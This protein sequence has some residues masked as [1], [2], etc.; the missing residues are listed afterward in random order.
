MEGSGC[1][2]QPLEEL[3]ARVSG[4][5]KKSSLAL[6]ASVMAL[7]SLGASAQQD[8]MVP[9]HIRAVKVD[10]TAWQ[11][12]QAGGQRER[13]SEGDF[14]RQGNVVETASDGS[15]ILLFDNGSTMNLR[16]GSKFSI[17]EFL[18]EPFD[19]QTIDYRKIE[20]E[21]SKSVTKVAIKE[22]AVFFDIPKLKISKGSSYNISNPVGTAGI[23]GTAGFV[24]QDSMGCTSGSFQA[25]TQTGQAMTLTAGQTTGFAPGGNFGPPPGNA[26]QNM[27]GAQQNSQT[28]RQDV[29]AEPF[30][31]APSQS[32]LSGN[33]TELTAEQ[34]ESIEQAAKQGEEALVEAVKQV[35][36]ENPESAAA[37]AALAASLNPDAAP[38]IAAAAA[39]AVPQSQSSALAP[40][41]AEAVA[42][43]VTDSAPQIAAAVASVVQDA[44]PQVAA[45]VAAAA[46]S[47]AAAVAQSVAQVVPS[48]AGNIAS[49]V[50][51]AI[52]GA[53]AN[54]V[55]NAAQQGAQQ[56]S[57]ANTGGGTGGTSGGSG[58]GSAP[59]L[60]GG[61]GGGGGGGGTGGGSSGGG[62]IYSN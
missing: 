59:A 39:A 7:L 22:G 9:G 24:A 52:P 51:N 10:G 58:G 56:G 1:I 26:G 48:Q 15:V 60:P 46:P 4:A 55:N 19:T 32:S 20:A 33:T 2:C 23:R 17:N 36:S 54:A 14:L 16:P 44:A 21:P 28:A 13:L 40:Q 34:S 27:Q 42:N 18:R 45:A 25:T 50:T 5:M 53:D 38:Q 11:I 61:F 62:S 43:T 30:S 31:G 37:A 41:I 6:A 8:Q 49:A 3:Y 12:K 35:A 57:Q 29:P 47:Q